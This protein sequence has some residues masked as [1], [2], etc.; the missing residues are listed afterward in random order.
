MRRLL[1]VV[2]AFVLVS[3]CGNGDP[4]GSDLDA[5]SV[6]GDAVPR[7]DVE[8]GTTV[9]DTES[10]VV[11]AGGGDEIVE[12]DVVKLN[13]LA[14][15][16]RTGE[17]F[18]SSYAT[19][20]TTTLRLNESVLPGFVKALVGQKVGSRVLALIPPGDGFGSAR[21]ELG[22]Q[23]GDTM[24]FVF[25][26]VAV[27]P[28][29]ATGESKDLPDDLP[30]LELDDDGRPVGFEVGH[31]TIDPNPPSSAHVVIEGDGDP[32]EA[33][34]FVTVQYVGQIHPD[35]EVF[36]SSWKNGSPLT[37]QLSTGRLIDCWV[38][39][40]VGTPVGSRVVLVCPPDT[41]YGDAGSPP[42]IG[43][44]DTLLFAIDVLDAS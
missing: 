19:G 5:I 37:D 6:S 33:D 38:D 12:G 29:E 36:D 23:A 40:L 22:L 2:S 26:V 11:K 31:G 17:E 7:A 34:Q 30:Q 32:V 9:S 21:T 14:I 25:D 24:A 13:Y 27:L 15:N 4:S 43:G 20:R 1:C 39:Q 41:A 44:G 18:D 28:V 42:A 3:A 16:G 8:A 35:G 10:K